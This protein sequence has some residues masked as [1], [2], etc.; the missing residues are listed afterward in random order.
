MAYNLGSLSG[1]V[2]S[3]VIWIIYFL[4]SRRSA[5][6]FRHRVDGSVIPLE[7]GNATAGFATVPNPPPLPGAP[8]LFHIAGAPTAVATESFTPPPSP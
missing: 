4:V 5:A 7:G 3:S 1:S 6:T 2:I 8:G